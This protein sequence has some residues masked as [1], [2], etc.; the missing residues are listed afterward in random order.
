MPRLI[1]ALAVVSLFAIQGLGLMMVQ[2]IST[3]KVV[4]FDPFVVTKTVD[5][6]SPMSLR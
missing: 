2:P 1:A 4:K 5:R 3:P 6:A